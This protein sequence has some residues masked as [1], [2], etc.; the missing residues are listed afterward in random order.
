VTDDDFRLMWTDSTL[1]R[2]QIAERSG[3]TRVQIYRKADA[4]GLPPRTQVMLPTHGVTRE[5]FTEMWMDYS[6]TRAEVSFILGIPKSSCFTLAKAWGL[7]VERDGFR[8]NCN[9]P[10]PTPEEIRE[11]CAE[12]RSRWT[13]E[14]WEMRSKG[15]SPQ[16]RA[17]S[18]DGTNCKFSSATPI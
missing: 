9:N 10:D 13:D 17:F 14:E 5:R 4:L 11:R 12:I 3:L 6:Y 2:D 18:Y 8:Q 16:L 1:N 7:P 15:S